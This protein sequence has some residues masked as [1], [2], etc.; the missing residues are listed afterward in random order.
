M[1]GR[2]SMRNTFKGFVFV[3]KK[4]PPQYFAAFLGWILRGDFFRSK[5]YTPMQWIFCKCQMISLSKCTKPIAV[6]YT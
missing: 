4:I 6:E 3:V 5:T 2:L 1:F